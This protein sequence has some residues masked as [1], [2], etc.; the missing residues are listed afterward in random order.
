MSGIAHKDISKQ[1]HVKGLCWSRVDFLLSYGTID[2]STDRCCIAINIVT[3]E[4]ALLSG[5]DQ[6][7][8]NLRRNRLLCM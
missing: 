2:G 8:Q 1:C 3:N 6:P 7:V 4:R 5:L